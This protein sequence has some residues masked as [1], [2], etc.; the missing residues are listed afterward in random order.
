MGIHIILVS[1]FNIIFNYSM[2]DTCTVFLLVLI[3]AIA[4]ALP[5]IWVKEINTM[6]AC[7]SSL[8]AL[9]T[10]ATYAFI[11][12][13]HSI[14]ELDTDIITKMLISG[15][16]YGLGLLLYIEAIKYGNIT[17]LNMQTVL[18]F[19][20]STAIAFLLLGEEATTCK[21]GGILVALL[22]A[23]LLIYDQVDGK[24]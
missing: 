13:G 7:V 6:T 18:I 11:I 8:F 15:F 1:I 24:K 22:G 21:I 3:S 19:V 14:S 12:K 9:L 5:M 2:N 4:Y 16:F 23:G 17:L 10:L 20:L